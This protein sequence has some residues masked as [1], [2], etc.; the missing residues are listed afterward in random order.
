MCGNL[1]IWGYIWAILSVLI[2]ASCSVSYYYA[3]WLTATPHLSGIV[4]TNETVMAKTPLCSGTNATILSTTFTFSTFRR[5]NYWNFE[6]SA[7]I[8]YYI[9]KKCGRYSDFSGNDGIPSQAW[10][11][12]AI[13][14]G[15]GCGLLIMVALVA[16]FALFIKGIF[17]K[18]VAGISGFFQFL[19]FV[20]LAA[21]VIVYPI[22]LD[23][24][25]VRGE[26]CGGSAGRFKLGDCSFGWAYWV[27]V[28]SALAVLIIACLS[29]VARK[30]GD[31]LYKRGYVI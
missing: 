26:A 14:G 21:T 4:A 5:C 17:N 28:G 6:G 1:T 30:N 2:A 8:C 18:Y 7:D 24:E 16:F 31:S 9:E 22:G 11:A 29:P 20:L 3:E 23:A 15:I 12:G 10:Q 19:A 25:R 27:S 13:M